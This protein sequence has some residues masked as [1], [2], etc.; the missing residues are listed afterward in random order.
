[1]VKETAQRLMARLGPRRLGKL[2]RRADLRLA[3]YGL[4]WSG[5]GVKGPVTSDRQTAV[6]REGRMSV[7]WDH[8]P[9]HEATP[10]TV[11]RSVCSRGACT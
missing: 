1:M 5:R 10:A 7:I 9:R 3:L 2:E 6:I 4:G 8:F 11:C